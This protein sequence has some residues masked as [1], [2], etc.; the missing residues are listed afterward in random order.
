MCPDSYRDADERQAIAYFE[1]NPGYHCM[2][3]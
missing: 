2:H 1:F 3:H